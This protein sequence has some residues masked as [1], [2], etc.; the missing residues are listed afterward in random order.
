MASAPV[1]CATPTLPMS[2]PAEPLHAEAELR[3]LNRALRMLSDSNQALIRA[4][5]EA[6]LLREICRIAVEVGGYRMAW[7]GVPE[8]D[9]EKSVRVAAVV[10]FEAGYIEAMRITWADELHGRGPAGTAI[11]TGRPHVIH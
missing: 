8:H 11:R 2:D 9:A 4:T 6:A 10:G 7:V 5:D 1:C 3:R